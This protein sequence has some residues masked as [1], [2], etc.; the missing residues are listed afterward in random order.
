[1]TNIAV[2]TDTD[3]LLHLFNNIDGG[4]SPWGIS[5]HTDWI[6][7]GHRA[8]MRAIERALKREIPDGEDVPEPGVAV[9]AKKLN[10]MRVGLY[11][12]KLFEGRILRKLSKDIIWDARASAFD[13]EF[14][15][16]IR[17]YKAYHANWG[18]I[19]E[20][21]G[22]AILGAEQLLGGE[23]G[24]P[25]A[26]AVAA[27]LGGPLTGRADCVINITDPARVLANTGLHVL[28]GRY[29]FDYKFSSRHGPKDD[30]KYGPDNLQ[31][32][33]YLWLDAVEHGE[34]SAIGVIFERIIGHREI[35]KAKSYA[36]YVVYP[37]MDGEERLR[38]VVT[39]SMR[40]QQD[41]Q[42]NP[43]ACMDA[44]GRPCYFKYSG[45]CRGY[46][47]EGEET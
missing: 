44:Y 31:A 10:Y 8:R 29:V 18:S 38:A 36:S 13:L 32:Q 21:W 37:Q 16:A 26:E 45:Q 15:E 2:A 27:S 7:C 17:L 24:S 6:E 47:T 19:E 3:Y 46:L 4:P 5:T 25:T 43:T 14:I 39:L 9:V 23:E 20:K 40:S 34:D 30:L 28:P 22:C 42:P 41:P 35:S 1:M 33:A 12:H 11:G